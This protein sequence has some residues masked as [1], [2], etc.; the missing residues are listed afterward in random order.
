M[1]SL[2]VGAAAPDAV[3]TVQESLLRALQNSWK[4]ET[5][6]KEDIAKLSGDPIGLL[7]RLAIADRLAPM[8]ASAPNIQGNPRIVKRLL[9]AITLRQ[10]LAQRRGM[11]VDLSTLA[12]LAVFERCT[13]DQATLTLY[14]LI[15]E[16]QDVER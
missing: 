14:R 6:T 9:N 13:D 5:F 16:D 3:Q 7:D 8:L 10:V 2:F 15:S 1:Y 11:N 4:G 12:K